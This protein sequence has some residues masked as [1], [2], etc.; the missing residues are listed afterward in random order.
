MQVSEHDMP[1]LVYTTC[2]SVETAEEIAGALVEDSLA[3][4]VNII[5]EMISVYAWQGQRQRDDEV[6]M[7]VKTMA[8]MAN[9]VIERINELHPYD[10]PAGLVLPAVGG[11]SEFV[12]WI[13]EQTSQR[14]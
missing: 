9:S 7:L 6:V 5:P 3:A 10:V 1:V 4:C 13:K 8:G 14:T 11:S 12:D 2:P